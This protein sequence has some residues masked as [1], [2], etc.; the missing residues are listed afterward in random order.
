MIVAL[1]YLGF[2]VTMVGSVSLRRL[3]LR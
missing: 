1:T 2:S 3:A